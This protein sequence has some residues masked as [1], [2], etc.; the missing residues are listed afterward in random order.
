MAWQKYQL[1]AVLARTGLETI[2]AILD[3]AEFDQ[4]SSEGP[5]ELAAAAGGLFGSVAAPCFFPLS[6]LEAIR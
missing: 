3:S 6:R 1:V 2:L 5:D 4:D